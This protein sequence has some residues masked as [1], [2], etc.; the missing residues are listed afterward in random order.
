MHLDEELQHAL[1][2]VAK[3]EAAGYQSAYCWTPEWDHHHQ[4]QQ[5]N[6]LPIYGND[7][8]SH[9]DAEQYGRLPSVDAAFSRFSGVGGGQLPE[10]FDYSGGYQPTQY[11]VSA[12]DFAS[13]F[14]SFP[15]EFQQSQ[16]NIEESLRVVDDFDLN[17]IRGDPTTLS[18]ADSSQ[19]MDNR[20]QSS[21]YGEIEPVY[22]VGHLVSTQ[23]C[24]PPV[25]F[26]N[27]LLDG[28]KSEPTAMTL[29]GGNQIVLSRDEGLVL[30][31]EQNRYFEARVEPP[32]RDNH[33]ESYGSAQSD[34]GSAPSYPCLWLDCGCSFGEQTSLVQHIERRH[35]ESSST[36]G[37]GGNRRLHKLD[38]DRDKSRGEQQPHQQQEPDCQFAC[39]WKGCSR[40]RPFNARYKLLIHMRVHSGE[41]P[42]KCP[43]AGCKKA[44]S[45]LENLKIHQR[46]HTGE[47]PYACQHRGCTKAFSN[48]SD[49]AK[50]QRTHY[51]TKPYACQ[52][53]GCG[54]RYTDPSSLRKHAKNHADV[55]SGLP[56]SDARSHPSS[57]K[58]SANRRTSSSSSA[59]SILNNNGYRHQPVGLQQVTRHASV[60]SDYGS[61][62][63]Q[64]SI[65]DGFDDAELKSYP[66]SPRLARVPNNQLDEYVPYESVAR[67]LV[68]DRSSQHHL[69]L[70][71]IGYTADEDIS[72]LHDLGSDIEFLE[73]NSLDDSVFMGE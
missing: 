72:D 32:E 3:R 28:I 47:R 71:N 24:S 29:D 26:G 67:F 20:Q 30:A 39:L 57:C 31:S 40:D 61:Q 41:K 69:G 65:H 16:V 36:S 18:N 33:E 66:V 49:R 48:S 37:H 43:F 11:Q 1:A 25:T 59:S 55:T 17:L 14:F 19:A 51:D 22:P 68:D 62:K 56:A 64:Q 60:T 35:V 53:A 42:N 63:D 6:Q 27:E 8:W 4:Q 13:S 73:L 38:K 46:S 10:D 44:F 5:Q 52:V 54:K 23:P 2:Q 21:D 9:Q 70:D 12:N 34:D 50:H 7:C 15:S 58:A 45:R